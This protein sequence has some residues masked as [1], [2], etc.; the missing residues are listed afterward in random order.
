M[1]VKQYNEMHKNN[2][3]DPLTKY[4]QTK[5]MQRLKGKG[6][7]CGMDYVGVKSMRPKEP[8]TRYD[9]SFNVGHSAWT[10]SNDLNIALT[11]A[12]HDAGTLDFSHVNSFKKGQGAT[13]ENDEL[14]VKSVLLKDEELLT[15][16]REDGINIDDVCDAEK[17][18]VVDKPHP[19][20]CL[21]RADGILSTCLIWAGTHN[22]EEIRKLYY[23]LSY[24]P[25]IDGMVIDYPSERLIDLDGNIIFNGELIIDENSHPEAAN[26]ED[27]FK[28]INVYSSILLTKESHYITKVFGLVLNY[29]EDVKLITE[30]DL[31]HYSEQEVIERILDSRYKQVWQDFVNI[32]RVDYANQND[33]DELIIHDARNKIR[34]ANPLCWAQT[35]LSEIHGVSKY[36][37]QELN[38]LEDAIANI[39][40][41]L[42]GNLSKETSLILKK[43]QKR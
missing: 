41:P 18:P 37:Y 24:L 14:D 4:F 27:F 36:S 39:D 34:Y 21:D 40:K 42:V 11:G 6:F 10:F 33:N 15:Y 13:Q 20:L 9:H 12:F 38:P 3:S 29:Y 5:T 7:Y 23:M 8:Y 19:A 31:F 1:L 16:L 32:T 30:S 35:G 22:I 26:Y 28:A 25:N 17:Y 43:Y 2:Y